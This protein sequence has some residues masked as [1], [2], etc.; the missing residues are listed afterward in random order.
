[1]DWRRYFDGLAGGVFAGVG[2]A[3]GVAVVGL[4]ILGCVELTQIVGNR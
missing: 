4:V 1:M 3:L 2:I